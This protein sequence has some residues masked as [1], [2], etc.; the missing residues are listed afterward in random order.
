M[1]KKAT[2]IGA[3]R[4]SCSFP[5]C[6]Q[7][8]DKDA[9]LG[10]CKQHAEAVD[11]DWRYN[12]WAIAEL[13]ILPLFIEHAELLGNEMVEGILREGLA[14]AKHEARHWHEVSERLHASV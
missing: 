14:R 1:P 4:K 3:G 5:G 2:E 9:P 8:R 13:E 12:A 11:A 7:E 10:L 6:C